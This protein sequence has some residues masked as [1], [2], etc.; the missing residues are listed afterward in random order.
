MLVS[1]R[2]G[3]CG[4][5]IWQ[6]IEDGTVTINGAGTCLRPWSARRVIRQLTR[7]ATVAP[8]LTYGQS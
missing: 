1:S 5:T 3:G 8:P 2:Y 6:S 7:T 4:R